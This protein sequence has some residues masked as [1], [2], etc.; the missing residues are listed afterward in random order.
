MDLHIDGR[1]AWAYTG[2]RP[3]DPSRPTVVMVHGALSDHSLWG[4]QSRWL[5]H[6]GQSVLVVDLPGHGRSDG[7][8]LV[9][10]EAM[11]DWLIALLAAAAAVRP[12]LVGHSMGS[13]VALET[14][15]RLGGAA[16][17]LVMVGTAFPMKVAPALMQ[18]SLETP[19][20]AI[21]RVTAFSVGSLATKP[22]APGPG[23]WLHGGLRQLMRRQQAAYAAAGHGNLFHQDF[24]ACDAYAAALEAAGRVQ[25]PAR[26]VLGTADVMTPPKA[27]ARLREALD[28]SVTLLPSGHTLPGE[29][30][31]GVLDAL[32]EVLAP[33]P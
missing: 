22:G 20:E 14:A 4:L 1:R 10:V 28:A 8:A 29:A 12:A 32:R 7:P 6:H 30:P 23:S 26:L 5:A 24:S 27:A 13:L 25:C 33:A 18:A 2:G 19:L 9:S 16:R 21:D 11:A 15:A 3:F 31:D 17:A